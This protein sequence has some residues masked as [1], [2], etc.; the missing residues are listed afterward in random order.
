MKKT[1]KNLLL[2]GL[3]ICLLVSS[4]VLSSP[5]GRVQADTTFT[6]TL[7]PVANGDLQQIGYQYPSSGNHWDKVD[8]VSQDGGNTFV[9][10]NPGYAVSQTD[11]YQLSNL[12]GTVSGILN[13]TVYAYAQKTSGASSSYVLLALKTGN[14]VSY[15]SVNWIT[16]AAAGEMLGYSVERNY[17]GRAPGQPRELPG[18][19]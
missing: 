2:T 11:V 18:G 13:V 15:S 1:T 10:T 3:S 7:R 9:Y 16:P 17:H 5:I 12:V 19:L 8:E 4:I 14:T 6:A